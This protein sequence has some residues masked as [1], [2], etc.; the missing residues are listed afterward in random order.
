MPPNRAAGRS[1]TVE[2][3]VSLTP[4]HHRW[5]ILALTML[6]QAL[7][8]GIHQFTFAFWVVP[9]LDEFQAPRSQLMLIITLSSITMAMI[10]PFIGI[11][12][13]RFPAR[14]LFCTGTL[15]LAGGLALISFARNHWEIL[16]LYVLILPVGVA[17]IGQLGCQTLI[18][19]WF[20]ENRGFAIGLS[21]VGVSIGAFIMPP[22]TTMLLA[23]GG[24]R[25]AFQVLA[26]LVIVLL[27][28][29][30]WLALARQPDTAG[31]AKSNLGSATATQWTTAL[32]LRNRDF[33]IIS[34]GIA[35]VLFAGLPLMYN[36]GAYARDLGIAQSQAALVASLGAIAF[37]AGKVGFGKLTDKLSHP[38]CYWI[39]G[40]LMIVGVTLVSQASGFLSLLLGQVLTLLG[41]GCVLPF[42]SSMIAARFGVHAF[43][44]VAGLATFIMGSGA[45]A[46]F[47]AGLI[48]D[49]SGSYAAAFITMLLPLALAMIAMR[50]LSAK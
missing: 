38:L 41:Q 17:L 29:A 34:C 19:R 2:T 37:A 20:V 45:L 10:S 36:I 1:Q 49:S 30:A 12:L 28:P 42:T 32:L 48:R 43:G 5:N 24:W 11:A 27:L 23:A 25:H 21:A 13:D 18:T 4:W 46:P 40:S 14:R 44:Q 8:L 6:S 16:L 3:R 39:A 9:W 26:A 31:D 15:L 7:G 22:L 33:W 35:A 50:W 47:F